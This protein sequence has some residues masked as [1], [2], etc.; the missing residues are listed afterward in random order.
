VQGGRAQL[1]IGGQVGKGAGERRGWWESRGSRLGTHLIL[2]VHIGFVIEEKADDLDMALI[3]RHVQADVGSLMW[4][5]FWGARL[6]IVLERISHWDGCWAIRGTQ[7]NGVEVRGSSWRRRTN[8]SSY[9]SGEPPAESSFVT[10][11]TLEDLT[12]L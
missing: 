11:D 4:R 8:G 1:P 12:A 10:S 3:R 9:F 2:S 6:W 7:G 5:R